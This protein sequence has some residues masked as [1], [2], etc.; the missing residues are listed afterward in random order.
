MAGISRMPEPITLETTTAAAS[1][2]PS[3]RSSR[4]SGSGRTPAGGSAAGRPVIDRPSFREQ[5][6]VDAVFAQPGPLSRSL[7]HVQLDLRVLEQRVLQH[8]GAGGRTGV[9][10]IAGQV[11]RTEAGAGLERVAVRGPDHLR[12]E[13]L[14]VA[15]DAEHGVQLQVGERSIGAVPD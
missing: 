12:A 3:R 15:D 11:E 1:T 7:L 4:P 5:L 14:G 9:A 2:V 13:L 8:L 6:P 10:E